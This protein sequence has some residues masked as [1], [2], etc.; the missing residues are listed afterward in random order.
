MLLFQ[1]ALKAGLSA[2]EVE[3]LLKLATSQQIKDK[4]KSATQEALDHG[5]SFTFLSPLSLFI[6]THTL[7][8]ALALLPMVHVVL[9]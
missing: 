8:L 3:E 2:S 4:L 5:V 7:T 9:V 1:A 6:T